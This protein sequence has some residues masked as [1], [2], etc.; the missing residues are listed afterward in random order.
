MKI[1]VIGSVSQ[2]N[3]IKRVADEYIKLGNDVRYVKPEDKDLAELIHLCFLTIEA[4]ADMVVVVPKSC[5][6]VLDI[7]HGTMYEIEFA[8]RVKKPVVIHYE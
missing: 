1:Y 5:A 4:W 3:Q 2:A 7:G 8:K 6:R